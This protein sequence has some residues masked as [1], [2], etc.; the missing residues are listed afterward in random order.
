MIPVTCSSCERYR[1]PW[2]SF[3]SHVR[4]ASYIGLSV[5]MGA[6]RCS[7]ATLRWSPQSVSGAGRCAK[8]L[9]DPA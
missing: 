3:P 6:T 2:P 7:F 1:L 4:V 5:P 8:P 9:T